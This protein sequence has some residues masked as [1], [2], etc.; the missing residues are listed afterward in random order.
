MI[1]LE[2][3]RL[4]QTFFCPTFSQRPPTPTRLFLSIWKPLHRIGKLIRNCSK[5]FNVNVKQTGGEAC[6]VFMHARL[7]RRQKVRVS[8]QNRKQTWRGDKVYSKVS[9]AR[10]HT[11]LRP[12]R[13]TQASPKTERSVS[14]QKLQ[15][16]QTARGKER[17]TP[18]TPELHNT[19][20]P[21]LS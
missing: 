6:P 11:H 19:K 20:S 8:G 18:S 17:W 14:S 5:K 1:F 4:T 3:G 13:K 16:T 9:F 10:S 2:Y 21:I 7:T 15:T 12:Q